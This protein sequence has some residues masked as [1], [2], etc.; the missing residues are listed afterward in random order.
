M[1]LRVEKITDQHLLEKAFQ[2]RKLVFVIEQGVNP[3]DEYDQFENDST[4]FLAFFNEKPVGT[5]RWRFTE[6]GIK[7]ERFAVV[8]QERGK[9][10]GKALVKA[11]LVDLKTNNSADGKIRYLHAQL[12][13]IPLYSKFGFEKVGEMFEEC[14]ILHYKMQFS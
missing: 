3:S 9:G 2:I 1:N 12:D 8:P 11:V 7:L 5:A 14:G 13:A 10:I 6:K 4:H